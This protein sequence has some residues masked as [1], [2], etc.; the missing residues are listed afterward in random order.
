MRVYPIIS[1]ILT[2][3]IVLVSCRRTTVNPVDQDILDIPYEP[4]LMQPTLPP[5]Y[6]GFEQ[7]NDNLMTFDGVALGRSL[8]Y[9]P[10]LSIDS[11]VSC[12]GCHFQSLGFTDGLKVS[13][14]VDQTPGLRSSMSL[15]DIAFHSDGLFWDGRSQTLEEQALHPVEDP[16]EMKDTWANVEGKLQNHPTY[17]GM[18]RKAFGIQSRDDMT[19]DLVTKALAQFERSLI[20][21]GNSRFDQF[22]RGEIGLEEDEIDG[23]LMFFDLRPGELPDAECGHCHSQ[24]LF[25]TFEYFNNGLDPASDFMSFQDAGRGAVSGDI[26][27]NGKFKVPTLRNIAHSAPYMHDGRFNTLAE[28]VDH[29]N[30]GGNLSPNKHPLISPLGLNETHKASLIAFLHTLTD[31]TFLNNPAFSDPNE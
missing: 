20:S 1:I 12:A 13:L 6:P 16:L 22:I 7:P 26:T 19:R 4:I 21:S 23:Y 29:Y 24:P 14:G 18:F 2:V 9:D 17:P 25:T 15:V 31:T 30:Q 10:I 8:F 28:V 27:D 3:F 5:G 11:T